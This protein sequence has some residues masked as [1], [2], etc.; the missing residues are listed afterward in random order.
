MQNIN[1]MMTSNTK[2]IADYLK[3]FESYSFL[4]TQDIHERFQVV[5]PW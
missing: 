2:D 1:A 4:Y 5:R 3:G